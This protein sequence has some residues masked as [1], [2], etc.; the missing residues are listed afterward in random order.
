MKRNLLFFVGAL[1]FLGNVICVNAMEENY[2]EPADFGKDKID[3]TWFTEGP[4]KQD[5]DFKRGV[6]L[7]RSVCNRLYNAK[8]GD[9]KK[10]IYH[11]HEGELAKYS[12]PGFFQL[13]GRFC[14]NQRVR[15][16]FHNIRAKHVKEVSTEDRFGNIL[17]TP[18]MVEL[19][20]TEYNNELLSAYD[21]EKVGE[22]VWL[23]TEK[24]VE[25][26]LKQDKNLRQEI[27]NEYISSPEWQASKSSIFRRGL[28][29][30]IFGTLGTGATIGGVYFATKYLMNRGE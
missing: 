27:A 18:A 10:S 6:L 23:E 11:E 17:T 9:G 25:N 30:G 2:K 15:E 26:Y 8:N 7:G 14:N 13:R 19:D 4:K 22:V 5:E 28:C 24:R 29:V 12:L 21:K 1:L 3:A 20:I 16:A